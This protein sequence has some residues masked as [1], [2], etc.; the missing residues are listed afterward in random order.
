MLGSDKGLKSE[1]I[2][3]YGKNTIIS[4]SSEV[5]M[6]VFFQAIKGSNSQ[7]SMTLLIDLAVIHRL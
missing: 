4:I 1:R 6:S 2:T 3:K 5:E 7:N